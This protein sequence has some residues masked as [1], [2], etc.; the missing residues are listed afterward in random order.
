MDFHMKTTLVLSDE[1]MLNL[2][3]EAATRRSTMSSLVE[4]AL[5]HYFNDKSPAME[6][7][8]LPTFRGGQALLD[9][10]DRDALAH[11]MDGR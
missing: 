9:I 3:R 11:A 1:T 7:P 5:R 10:S 6:L 8:E 4:T 2:K